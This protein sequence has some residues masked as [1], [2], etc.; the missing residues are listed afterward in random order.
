MKCLKCLKYFDFTRIYTGG[1]KRDLNRVL[2]V[3]SDMF[4]GGDDNFQH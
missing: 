1:N 3:E 2:S 4:E